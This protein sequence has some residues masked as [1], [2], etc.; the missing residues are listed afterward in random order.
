MIVLGLSPNMTALAVVWLW[1]VDIASDGLL[2]LCVISPALLLRNGSKFLMLVFQIR[3]RWSRPLF[4]STDC[5][6]TVMV[7]KISEKS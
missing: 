1:H 5:L 4:L 3:K 6:F 2:V 7:Y